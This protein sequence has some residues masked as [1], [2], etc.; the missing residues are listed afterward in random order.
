M[1]VTDKFQHLSNLKK[2][3]FIS[4]CC[5]SIKD[6]PSWHTALLPMFFQGPHPSHLVILLF[7]MWILRCCCSLASSQGKIKKA[8]RNA[9]GGGGGGAYRSDLDGTSFTFTHFPMAKTM[10]QPHLKAR[11][12]EKQ[13][14]CVPRTKRKQV[15]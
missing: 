11:R 3:K 13:C 15:C 10:I 1:A 14:S 9:Y 7:P 8:W 12:L 4:Y 5:K 6:V 2:E